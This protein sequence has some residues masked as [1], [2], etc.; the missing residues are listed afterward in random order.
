MTQL[1]LSKRL[2]ISRA[3]VGQWE[4]N[5][6]SP[7]ISKLEEV[8]AILD[9]APEWLAYSVTPGEE[10]VVYRNPERD[11]MVWVYEVRFGDSLEDETKHDMWGLP[12][13]Y[14]TRELKSSPNHTIICDVNSNDAEP[15]FAFGD[16]VFVDTSDTRPS[17]AGVFAFWDGIGMAF[18]RMQAVPGEKPQVRITQKGADAYTIDLGSV[19]IKGRVKGRLQRG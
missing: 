11:N 8:A 1:D 16:K 18:A 7:S 12:G 3:A 14:L 6:T 10:R 2:G 13:D 17:P 19:K 15:D 5:T 9:V 4:I